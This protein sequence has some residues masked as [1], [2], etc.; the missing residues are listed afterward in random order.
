[1]NILPC[2]VEYLFGH[3]R[4]DVPAV[5]PPN[6]SCTPRTP[7]QCGSTRS[8]EV[9]DAVQVLLSNIQNLSR[10]P[11][12]C[13]AQLKLSPILVT[14]KK[15]NSPQAKISTIHQLH[16]LRGEESSISH[17]I[18]GLSASLF[19]FCLP[20]NFSPSSPAYSQLLF[21]YFHHISP[22]ISPSSLC[23]K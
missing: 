17:H 8:R 2:G 23:R 4:S 19:C 1:M 13:S 15:I 18:F 14:V 22:P 5:S 16:V 7:Q 12:L 9:F 20:T 6:F 11:T 21:L 10:L 3:L